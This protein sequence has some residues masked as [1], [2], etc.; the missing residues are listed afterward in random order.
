MST[1]GWM[2][3]ARIAR[4]LSNTGANELFLSEIDIMS[5]YASRVVQFAEEA[6]IDKRT[7]AVNGDTERYWY[8]AIS[9][10]MDKDFAQITWQN[11][12]QI[13]MWH[14]LLCDGGT[15]ENPKKILS[16]MGMPCSFVLEMLADR[17]KEVYFMNNN[18]LFFFEKFFL[19][20]NEVSSYGEIRYSSVDIS[21]IQ[22]GTLDG[23]FDFVRTGGFGIQKITTDILSSLMSSVKVGGSFVLSDSADFGELYTEP[24]KELLL[25]AWDNGKYI[26]GRSD[27]ISYHLPYDVGLTVAKRVA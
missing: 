2:N 24:I 6:A 12:A 10:N 22:S 21:D 3:R 1:S 13:K 9:Q 8:E 14:D 7:I 20:Y 27:F 23:Y 5:D 26:C 15:V 25:T 4:R 16:Y 17:T 18:D 11:V 19:P